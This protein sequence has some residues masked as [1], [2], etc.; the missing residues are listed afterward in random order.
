MFAPLS[1]AA[2]IED[3]EISIDHDEINEDL[4]PRL[5]MVAVYAQREKVVDALFLCFDGP[6]QLFAAMYLSCYGI[7]EEIE[8]EL[9]EELTML[10]EKQQEVLSEQEMERL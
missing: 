1:A 7:E 9:D 6:E 8:H 10:L 2:E 3:G 4:V 5:V